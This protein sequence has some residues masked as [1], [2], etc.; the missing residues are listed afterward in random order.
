MTT[1]CCSSPMK[2]SDRP[3][4]HFGRFCRVKKYKLRL[5]IERDR[6]RR[7]RCTTAGTFWEMEV[8]GGDK[9]CRCGMDSG[10]PGW[11]FKKP[12]TAG[13]LVIERLTC[14]CDPLKLDIPY[15]DTIDVFTCTFSYTI[16]RKFDLP[17]SERWDGSWQLAA[18]NHRHFVQ[19]YHSFEA[20]DLRGIESLARRI[21]KPNS[22][23]LTQEENYVL[24]CEPWL[25]WFFTN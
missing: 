12:D 16:P 9:L 5:H 18:W 2:V 24:F 11:A 19:L 8:G 1:R 14:G 21:N 13:V 7:D 25:S 3:C 20:T 15:T 22:L 6:R 4:M 10:G 23:D 17:S